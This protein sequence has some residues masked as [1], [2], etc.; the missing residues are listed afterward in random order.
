M[1]RFLLDEL[2]KAVGPISSRDLAEKIIGL[3]GKDARDRRLRNDMVKRVGKSL[4]LL[5]RQRMAN[6]MPGPNHGLVPSG[7]LF[8]L[9]QFVSKKALGETRAEIARFLLIATLD[10]LVERKRIADVP[11]SNPDAPIEPEPTA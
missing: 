1:R 9:D 8:L 5:R 6:S 11:V 4:K 2:R 10:A 3:E 7:S